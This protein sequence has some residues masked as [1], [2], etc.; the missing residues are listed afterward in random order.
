MAT[1]PEINSTTTESAMKQRLVTL[2]LSV[3]LTATASAAAFAQGG[4]LLASWHGH[5][6][7][8]RRV[9]GR[10]RDREHNGTG[11]VST[12]VT[13]DNGTVP[14]PGTEPGH[15]HG[16]DL[17]VGVQDRCPQR[18]RVERRRARVDPR[19]DGA[20]HPRGDDRRRRGS[21]VVQTQALGV[22]PPPTPRPSRPPPARTP[23]RPGFPPPPPRSTPPAA[24]PPPR[25]PPPAAGQDNITLDGV[26][27]QDNTLKT[28]DGFFAIVQPASRRD[29]RGDG[30]DGRAGRR[31]RRPGRGADQVRDPLGHATT[32]HGQRLLLLPQRRAQREHLVQQAQRPREAER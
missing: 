32:V 19:V 8:G 15:L 22:S 7:V 6:H 16:D 27:I 21:P 10:Y 23:T 4:A 24:P 12:T 20:R 11:T 25:P 31:Q 3:A 1:S 18:H 30:H 26:N 14:H 9:A 5:R 13:A 2:V 28:T 17:A 29:R